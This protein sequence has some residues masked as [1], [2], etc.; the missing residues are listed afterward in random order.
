MTVGC[1]VFLCW[2]IVHTT[3]CAITSVFRNGLPLTAAILSRDHMSSFGI[4]GGLNLL[5]SWFIIGAV[6]CP[7]GGQVL[8]AQSCLV[9][10]SDSLVSLKS[11]LQRDGNHIGVVASYWEVAVH[12]TV[13][14]NVLY[15]TSYHSSLFLLFHQ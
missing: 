12:V 14:F 15:S 2:G 1:L 13:L 10:T 3:S 4:P 8:T 6:I 9:T 11:E 5:Q 7:A